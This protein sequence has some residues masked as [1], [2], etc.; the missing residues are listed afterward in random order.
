MATGRQAVSGVEATFQALIEANPDAVL[1]VQDGCIRYVNPQAISMLGRAKPADLVDHAILE[2]VLPEDRARMLECVRE[3]LDA[4]EVTPPHEL[5]FIKPDDGVVDAEIILRRVMQNGVVTLLVVIRDITERRRMQ[6]HLRLADRMASVGTLA[7][8]VAHQINNPL[9]AV[10]ANLKFGAEQTLEL[11]RMVEKLPLQTGAVAPLMD[12]LSGL[13]Q[14]LEDSRQSGDRI[15]GIVQD[16]KTAAEAD[17]ATMGLVDVQ[18]VLES[19]IKLVWNEVRHRARVTRDFQEVPLVLANEN[20]LRQAFTN[21][22]LNASQTIREGAASD[23]EVH[24]KLWH[25]EEG[26]VR[27]EVRLPSGTCSPEDPQHLFDRFRARER[28]GERR[29]GMG[30]SVCQDIIQTLGGKLEVDTAPDMGTVFSAVLTAMHPP[31]L[32]TSSVGGT[33]P[34]RGRIL[35]VDDE[36]PILIL[37][38]RQ[39]CVDNEVVAVSK[40]REALELLCAGA[41][42]DLIL[43]DLMMPEMS[44]MDLYAELER[45]F[46]EHA[47]R[48]VFMTGGSF[49]P[50]S[51]QFLRKV[52]NPCLEKPFEESDLKRLVKTYLAVSNR[53]EERKQ[54]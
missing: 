45:K 40:G 51:Q 47:R 10:L 6:E 5:H 19:S 12:R 38:C 21:L 23:H 25:T 37:S 39:L 35:V 36:M 44:G 16:L 18:R 46:P 50:T 43:A 28:D 17:D 53:R 54:P 15:R 8:A 52:A 2:V 14:T 7:A 33:P 11:R 48:M 29:T 27:V 26:Q 49:T 42:F 31:S 1:V 22:L 32:V 34:T 13:L 30:L 3:A 4:P 24:L 9:A 20:R 41:Q